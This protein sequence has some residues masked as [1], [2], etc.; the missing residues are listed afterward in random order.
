MPSD[1]VFQ[2]KVTLRGSKPPIWRRFQ[3]ASDVTLEDLHFAVQSVM[4]W[5]NG[6]LH[7]FRI[8]DESYGEP[9]PEYGGEMLD[10]RKVTLQ[11][12]ANVERA[13]FLYIYDF[14]D[15]WQHIVQVEK[16]LPQDPEMRYPVCLAGKRACP[17]EDCGG[18]WGYMGLPEIISN[19]KHKEYDAMMEWLGDE[20]DPEEFDLDRMNAQLAHFSEG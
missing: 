2:C 12:I 17:P 1:R 15:N 4:G 9:H 13:H 8:G 16:I 18:I 19:P 14:G 5:S 10:E 20:F 11:R 3:I 7:E 6:H